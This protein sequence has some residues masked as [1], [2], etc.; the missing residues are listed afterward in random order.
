[1]TR[2]RLR[3]PDDR[4]HSH[5]HRQLV[6]EPDLVVRASSDRTLSGSDPG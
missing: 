1:M 6:F 2:R 3:V 4:R 5:R